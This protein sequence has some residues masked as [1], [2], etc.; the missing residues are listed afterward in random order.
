MQL[1][2]WRSSLPGSRK[3]SKMST[4]WAAHLQIV[5]RSVHF[6]FKNPQKGD[7]YYEKNSSYYG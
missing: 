3:M 4:V 7:K 5:D 1:T 6:C 2:D